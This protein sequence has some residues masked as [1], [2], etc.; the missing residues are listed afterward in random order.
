[1]VEIDG[2]AALDNQ[3]APCSSDRLCAC[4]HH[5]GSGPAARES[6]RA[7][8]EETRRTDRYSR[9]RWGKSGNRVRHVP[10]AGKVSTRPP[11]KLCPVAW[12]DATAA[13]FDRLVPGCS[14]ST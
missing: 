3:L 11:P 2:C 12:L 7:G 5:R 13:E 10:V 9:S 4:R 1:M 6:A 8:R 14:E